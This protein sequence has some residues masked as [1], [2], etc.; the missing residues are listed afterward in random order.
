MNILAHLAFSGDD[1]EIM[2]G[3]LMG[4]FVKGPLPGRYPPRLTV[5][6][7]LHRAIDSFANGHEAFIR[8]KRRLAPSF[9][10]YRGIL[11]DIYYDH[12]LAV[13]WGRYSDE[14]LHSFIGRARSIAGGF[15]HL[16]PERLVRLLPSMFD[17]WLPSYAD[18]A[19]I[20]LVLRRMSARIGRPNPLA[21][22][23]EELIRC[24][25][26]LRADFLHFHPALAAFVA[27]F[28]ASRA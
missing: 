22:G 3:N 21:Q 13:E 20:G 4:D 15:A 25:Q 12:F 2:A 16:M 14:P 7:E 9:G 26:E 11:V 27:D 23:E 24:R 8:S 19:G 28:L 6:L 17:E 10:H 18:S 5:G 1:P